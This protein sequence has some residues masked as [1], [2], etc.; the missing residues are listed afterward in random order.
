MENLHKKVG[1]QCLVIIPGA[2]IMGIGAFTQA[3]FQKELSKHL[4]NKFLFLKI[5][6]PNTFPH[7]SVR[8][9]ES[10]MH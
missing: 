10:A 7:T 3:P 6:R 8:F 1:W 4:K 9:T 5:A 2:A